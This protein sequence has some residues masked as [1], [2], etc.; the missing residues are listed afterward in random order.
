M[1]KGDYDVRRRVTA[2]FWVFR[3][4]TPSLA[5]LGARLPALNSAAFLRL[6]GF[7]LRAVSLPVLSVGSSPAM[8]FWAR[9]RPKRRS[10][11][12][13]RWRS[14]G[15]A[16]SHAVPERPARPVLPTL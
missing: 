11:L 13:R 12:P 2:P 10:I 1:S 5:F 15:E 14:V 16:S 4:F 9:V 3:G 7:T 8:V 6:N